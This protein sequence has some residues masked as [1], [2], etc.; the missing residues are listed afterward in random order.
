MKN[1]YFSEKNDKIISFENEEDSKNSDDIRKEEA[2]SNKLQQLKTVNAVSSPTPT[3][4]AFMKDEDFFA[5]I[6][7]FILLKTTYSLN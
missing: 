2:I 6:S 5:D 3:Q 1:N 4:N 7:K